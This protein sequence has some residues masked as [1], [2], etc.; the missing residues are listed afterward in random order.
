MP[1]FSATC[2]PVNFAAFASARIFSRSG[3]DE[4]QVDPGDDSMISLPHEGQRE[5]PASDE[6]CGHEDYDNHDAGRDA[7]A[8]QHRGGQGKHGAHRLSASRAPRLAPVSRE[9][10]LSLSQCRA[11]LDPGA[12]MSD[13]ALERLRDDLYRLAEVAIDAALGGHLRSCK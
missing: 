1:Y 11:L 9:V 6:P 7:R 8:A 12:A 13:D 4:L 10:R 3:A 5:V 2:L